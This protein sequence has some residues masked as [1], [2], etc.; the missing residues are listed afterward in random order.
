MNALLRI[1]GEEARDFEDFCRRDIQADGER[2]ARYLDEK[3]N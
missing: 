2:L 3:A 1:H